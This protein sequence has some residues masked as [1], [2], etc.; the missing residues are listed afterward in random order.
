[1]TPGLN[2]GHGEPVFGQICRHLLQAD[3]PQFMHIE[4]GAEP[5]H[6][7]LCRDCFRKLHKATQTAC[8]SCFNRVQIHDRHSGETSK[9]VVPK[10]PC[11]L[12]FQ[13][14]IVGPIHLQHPIQD[15]QP[16]PIQDQQIWLAVDSEGQV[17]QLNLDLGTTR[18]VAIIPDGSVTR[19]EADETYSLNLSSDGRFVVVYN[20][21]GS[22][23]VVIDLSTATT[24]MHLNRGDYEV[25]HCDFPATFFEH[26]SR[27]LLIHGTDWKRLD[28]SD[29]SNGELLTDRVTPEVRGEHDLDYFHCGLS[30]SPNQQY[31]FEDGWGWHPLGR[32]TVWDCQR[33]IGENVWESEDGPS[34][35]DLC[36][37][38]GV[39]GKA[40][41]WLNDTHLA[42]WG[43]GE[44]WNSMLPGIRIY[45]VST[46]QERW[47]F[48]GPNGKL[49]LDGDL[50]SFHDTDGTAVWDLETG[51]QLHQDETLH[52]DCYHPGAKTFLTQLT[53][54]R[55]QVS[56]LIRPIPTE[57]TGETVQSLA[58]FIQV[59][60][61]FDL[62]PVLADALEEAGCTDSM[63]LVHCR[64]NGSHEMKCWVTERIARSH[65]INQ[66]NE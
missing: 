49:V 33:W 63:M 28:I 31:V 62:L 14:E 43:L 13:H 55:F 50:I 20:N 35:R 8:K 58:S 37:R 5:P 54:G 39:W 9:L 17:L 18:V 45:D 24:T 34:R 61:R 65:T 15:L 60:R 46:G 53:D 48:P 26:K 2:C 4:R 38:D 25:E 47:S 16:I 59:N 12:R 3:A 6:Q 19:T 57:L 52:P 41:C 23:G 29:P 44:Y 36:Y 40:A 27:T 51:E 7:I 42:I 1:M 22:T 30:V 11:G 66:T 10:R 21:V 32:P 64:A 56:R